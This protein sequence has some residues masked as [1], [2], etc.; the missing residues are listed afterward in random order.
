MIENCRRLAECDALRAERDRLIVEREKS[1]PRV[2]TTKRAAYELSVTERYIRMLI[3]RKK[4]RAIAL[5]I[6]RLGITS[7]EL[8]RFIAEAG[9]V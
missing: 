7:E 2:Y 5:G 3:S 6:R 9:R 1:R 8:A 4:I